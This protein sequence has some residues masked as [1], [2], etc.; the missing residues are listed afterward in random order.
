[1]RGGTKHYSIHF[2]KIPNNALYPGVLVESG[3]PKTIGTRREEERRKGAI[4]KRS[5]GK[6]AEKDRKGAR[7]VTEAQTAGS[8][9]GRKA[10]AGERRGLIHCVCLLYQQ[11]YFFIQDRRKMLQQEREEQERSNLEKELKVRGIYVV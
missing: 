3:D 6:G 5:Q 11:D 2:N 9:K 4:E 8:G 10:A 7:G 1:M